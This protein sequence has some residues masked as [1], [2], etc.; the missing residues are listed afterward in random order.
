MQE[1]PHYFSGTITIE[2]TPEFIAKHKLTYEQPSELIIHIEVNES[3]YWRGNKEY[4]LSNLVIEKHEQEETGKYKIHHLEQMELERYYG[5]PEILDQFFSQIKPPEKVK[6]VLDAL[7]LKARPV[8]N[9]TIPI[10]HLLIYYVWKLITRNPELTERFKE[11]FEGR[12]PTYENVKKVWNQLDL[13]DEG[14]FAD[15]EIERLLEKFNIVKGYL[16]IEDVLEE[17]GE[18]ADEYN[19][20]HFK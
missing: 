20:K 7:F 17:P 12:E 18:Y 8:L 19:K 15:T 4:K 16:Y 14:V 13:P 9:S 1:K 2:I 3:Q 10:E 6:G 11:Q 5:Y